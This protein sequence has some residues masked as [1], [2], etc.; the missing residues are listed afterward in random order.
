MTTLALNR[1]SY[2]KGQD[3][4]IWDYPLYTK[5]LPIGNLNYNHILKK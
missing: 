5:F 4:I 1:A 3:N 2:Y